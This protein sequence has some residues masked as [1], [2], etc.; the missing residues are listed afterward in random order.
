LAKVTGG[1][2]PGD[3]V[4]KV[5]AARALMAL[6]QQQRDVIIEIYYHGRSAADAAAILG[7]PWA[8]V[9][10]L[11]YDALRAMRNIGRSRGGG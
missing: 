9:R 2:G 7:V 8:T 5:L 4:G 3:H 1:P 6:S 11:A 10:S